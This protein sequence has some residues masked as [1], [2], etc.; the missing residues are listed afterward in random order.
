MDI[1][2]ICQQSCNLPFTDQ[3]AHIFPKIIWM[4]SQERLSKAAIP[5]VI[6]GRRDF[7]KHPPSLAKQ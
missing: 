3:T 5:H 4:F 1:H 2:G 7:S 6:A